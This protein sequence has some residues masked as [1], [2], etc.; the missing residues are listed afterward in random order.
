MSP[1]RLLSLLLIF[2]LLACQASPPASLPL[3]T[4]D[5]NEISRPTDTPASLPDEKHCC[6]VRLHPDEALYVGDQISFEVIA[7]SP[8]PYLNQPL[9]VTLTVPP[10]PIGSTTFQ[11][12]GFDQ[13]TQA[14]LLWAWDTTALSTGEYTLHFSIPNLQ[15]EW[16]ETI[17]LLPRSAMPPAQQTAQWQTLTT[18]CCE[19]HFITNTAAHRDIEE[20]ATIVDET[21]QALQEKIPVE[22]SEPID[23]VLIPRLIGNGGFANSEINVS[24]LDRN[25]SAGDFATI[26]RHE[27]VHLLDQRANSEGRPSLFGE[28]MA[29]FLSGGHYFP[30]PLIP[31][32]AE[33]VRANKIIPLKKLSENFYQEQHEIAYLEAGALVAH[34][35]HRFGWQRVWKAY[36]AMSLRQGETHLQAIERALQSEFGISL[37]ELEEDFFAE[38]RTTAPNGL[39]T[40]DIQTLEAYYE[41]LRAYQQTLDPSAYYRTAW[42]LDARQMRQR[43]IVADYLR[44][45]SRAENLALELLL[46]EAGR[47][48][49][50]GDYRHAERILEEVSIVL[51]RI[52]AQNPNPFSGSPIAQSAWEVVQVLLAA[53]YEPQVW[54]L[55][56]DRAEVLITQ[57]TPA[58]KQVILERQNDGWRIISGASAATDDL[59]Q[60]TQ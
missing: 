34:L 55:S 50:A 2:F 38:L 9:T 8:D 52:Q 60:G 19:I 22:F 54:T 15:Q 4:A 23:V 33:L 10:T 24:Y 18:D 27:M 21:A 35:S 20:I 16:L 32:A 25:Y 53:G 57:T 6:E 39:F 26:L 3:P 43:G 45:P 28:G 11:P 29:V 46:N 56:S 42:M 47:A 40:L 14:T 1:K 58:L 17:T 30:E 44:H 41:T 48:R 13:R 59:I 5:G 49:R 7:P 12:Y 37:P 36:L 31:R 51:D